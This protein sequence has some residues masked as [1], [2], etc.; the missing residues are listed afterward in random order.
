[1]PVICRPATALNRAAQLK[2]SGR[3]T[4]RPMVTTSFDTA[5][6]V[7]R[8]RKMARSSTRPTSGASTNTDTSR[9]AHLGQPHTLWALKY[10]A[11]E[12]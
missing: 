7:R 6:A 10:M 11:A 2:I 8:W 3:A 4:L 12:M 1:M 5:E 9:A